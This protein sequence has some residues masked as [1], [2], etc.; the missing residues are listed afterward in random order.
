MAVSVHLNLLTRFSLKSPVLCCVCVRC[1]SSEKPLCLDAFIVAL[2]QACG[3]GKKR[4]LASTLELQ[5][6]SLEFCRACRTV[7]TLRVRVQAGTPVS[8]WFIFKPQHSLVP[9]STRVPLVRALALRWALPMDQLR[10]KAA[11]ELWDWLEDLVLTGTLRTGCLEAVVWP[12]SLKRLEL[13]T[14]LETPVQ[15]VSWPASLQ[16]LSFGKNFNQSIAGVVWPASLLQ[17]SFGHEFNQ[18]ITGVVWPASLEKLSFGKFFNQPITGVVWPSSLLE[19]SFGD[20]FMGSDFTQRVHGVEW[21]VSL[22]NVTRA[23]TRLLCMSASRRKRGD[24][25]VVY[26][27]KAPRVNGCKLSTCWCREWDSR[28]VGWS[29]RNLTGA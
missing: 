27:P 26:G 4:W 7:P 12:R 22:L 3:G 15:T 24:L 1:F 20:K 2:N 11:V 14:A 23:G 28:V 29:L 25:L 5:L 8:L 6:V 19:L 17:L 9:T 21:P 10:Q 16:R 18:P 13:E